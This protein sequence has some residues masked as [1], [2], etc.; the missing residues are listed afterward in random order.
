MGLGFRDYV[1]VFS[2]VLVMFFIFYIFLRWFMRIFEERLN[3]VEGLYS[4]LSE[5]LS[6]L[7]SELRELRS[8]VSKLRDTVRRLNGGV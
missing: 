4:N 7:I 5:S 2:S 1:D 3:F 6:I 8:E